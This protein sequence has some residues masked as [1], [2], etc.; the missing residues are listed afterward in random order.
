MSQAVAHNLSFRSTTKNW[1]NFWTC[2]D[3]TQV[4]ALRL[5]PAGH[6]NVNAL[7][8]NMTHWKSVPKKY[9]DDT[10]TVA[11]MC[12]MV[13]ADIKYCPFTIALFSLNPVSGHAALYKST[14]VNIP[15]KMQG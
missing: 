6:K 5:S 1:K 3:D 14:V 9:Q 10:T 11:I 13:Y 4:D 12:D 15:L 2:I 8:A 7:L